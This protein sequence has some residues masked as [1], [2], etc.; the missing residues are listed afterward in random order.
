MVERRNLRLARHVFVH[1]NLAHGTF[2]AMRKID[3]G[4]P[5]LMRHEL[6]LLIGGTKEEQA[7]VVQGCMTDVARNTLAHV[8]ITNRAIAPERRHVLGWIG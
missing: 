3:V 7:V 2:A 5:L 6:P 4:V 8:G 1:F